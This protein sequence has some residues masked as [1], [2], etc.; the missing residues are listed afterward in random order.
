M[1]DLL[2]QKKAKNIILMILLFY[3]QVHL[4]TFYRSC[5]NDSNNTHLDD[6]ID[7]KTIVS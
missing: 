7:H 2:V 1:V 4:Y 3:V 6:V 5:S